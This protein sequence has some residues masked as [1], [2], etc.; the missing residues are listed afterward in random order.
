MIYRASLETGEVPK[1]WREANVSPIFKKKGSK[2]E[3]VNYRPVSLTSVVCKVLESI[4]RDKIMKYLQENNLIAPQQHGFVPNKACNTN[5]LETMDRITEALDLGYIIDL[6]FL[7]F[8]KA[9]DKVSHAKLILCLFAIGIHTVL[10]RWIKAFLSNRK[11]RVVIGDS[12]SCWEDV[13]S[14]VPQGSV[15]GPLLFTIF[16]NDLPKIVKHLIRMYADDCKLIA[17]IKTLQDMIQLQNDIDSLQEWAKTWQMSFN[18]NKCKVMHLGNKNQRKDYTMKLGEDREPHILEKTELEKDLGVLVSSD[19]KWAAQVDKATKSANSVISQIRNSFSYFDKS[20]VK[21]L[22]VGLI[23][24]K[25][26]FAIQVW[27]PYFEKDKE[28][29][30]RVQHRATR[31]VPELRKKPYEYRLKMFGLTDLDIRRERGDLIEYY[32]IKNQL[33]KVEWSKEP[34]NLLLSKNLRPS[35]RRDDILVCE[36]LNKEHMSRKS[37]FLNRTVPIWNRLPINVKEAITLDSFKASL[38]KLERYSV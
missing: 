2:L 33:D 7:D 17:I 29:L 31:L 35:L 15:L 18:Y 3:S 10:V 14:G 22:Y 37:F 36:K 4:I 8:E 13:L 32:K 25:M 12:F 34:T 28:R 21:L 26:E 5:L 20:L 6:I 30:D 9:F 1:E 19:L 23:R 24:P 16:I 27:N 11:Q 38:D